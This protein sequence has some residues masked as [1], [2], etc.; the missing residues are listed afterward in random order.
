M[1]RKEPLDLSLGDLTNVFDG[2][3][4]L[5]G[6]DEFELLVQAIKNNNDNCNEEEKQ[7]LK[8]A[9]QRYSRYVKAI[10]LTELPT[11]ENGLN[12]YFQCSEN[13]DVTKLK[14]IKQIDNHIYDILSSSSSSTS[15]NKKQCFVR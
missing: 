5:D 7:L 1:K 3:K 11:L 2:L 10:D 12:K 14:L 13:N 15:N 9:H 6:D 8:T 4:V